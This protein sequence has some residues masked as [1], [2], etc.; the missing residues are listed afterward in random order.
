MEDRIAVH[1]A[2]LGLLEHDA[3]HGR[4]L[5]R[6][7]DVLF[8][9]GRP[10][11]FG[12]IYATLGRLERDGLVRLDGEERAQG[13]DRKRFV[14]T[15]D[16]V[17]DLDTWVSEPETPEPYLQSTLFTKVVLALLTGRDAAATLDAQRARHLGRMRE[18]TRM[19]A[20]A[21][22]VEALLADQALFHLEADLRWIDL[23][24]ARLDGIRSEVLG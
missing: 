16:G 21:P 8:A 9:H 11:R 12:Q 15:D 1:H 13:P 7:Y 17:A 14:I 4:G 20:G 24:E 22:P 10:L 23:A 2:L 18:L 3:R 19:R 6:G 5:M